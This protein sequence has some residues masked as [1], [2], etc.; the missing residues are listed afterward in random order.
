MKTVMRQF[1]RDE[2]GQ[3]TVEYMLI[4]A[5]IVTIFMQ[6]RTKMTGMLKKIFQGL[7]S[8]TD[9]ALEFEE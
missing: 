2:S 6:F 5:V 1:I 9:E 3:T 8:A 7:D 4:L